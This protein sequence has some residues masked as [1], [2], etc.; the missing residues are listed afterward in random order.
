MSREYSERLLD[1]MDEGIIDP[2]QLAEALIYWISEA[3]IRE[4]VRANDLELDDP[5]PEELNEWNVLDAQSG[6]SF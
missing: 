2:K 1:L 3:S 6:N 5:E 4:F